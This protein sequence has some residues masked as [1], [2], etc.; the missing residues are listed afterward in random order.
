MAGNCASIA[1]ALRACL[2][3]EAAPPTRRWVLADRVSNDRAQPGFQV[4]VRLSSVPARDSVGRIAHV[5]GI[6]VNAYGVF[7]LDVNGNQAATAYQ[8]RSIFNAIYLEDVTG[9]AFWPSINARDILDDTYYRHFANISGPYLHTGNQ[10]TAGQLPFPYGPTQTGDAGIPA[11]AGGGTQ[12]FPIGFYAPLVTLGA[13]SNPLAGLI[14][15]AAIQRQSNQGAFR[16]RLGTSVAGS[17]G[18]V[19]L[20]GFKNGQDQPGL[21]VWLDVVYLPAL[22]VD[23]SWTL[24]SYTLPD[25][26]G[27]LR[28][29]EATTEHAHIRYYP[30]DDPSS[31]Q[32]LSGQIAC[33]NLDIFTFSVA[34]FI[35]APGLSFADEVTRTALFLY[36]ER[37][38]A[39]VRDN[40]AQDLPLFTTNNGILAP[41]TL[42]I[43]PYRQR[44]AGP[45]K[46]DVTFKYGSMG[47][48]AWVRY[49]HRTVDCNEVARADELAKAVGCDPCSR[50]VVTDGKGAVTSSAKSNTTLLVMDPAAM[51]GA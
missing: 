42:S 23:P 39:S 38:S 22:A 43:L 30:E 9:H 7:D 37:D 8:L 1:A 28:R 20:T 47:G 26:S 5:R 4:D 48:N 45:A 19:T 32:A 16:F 14:P 15:L 50:T 51:R 33:N 6:F 49:N 29:P 13:G 12:Q 41:T 25:S 36:S 27:V 10:G 3:C 18:G 46:G 35:E 21:D 2:P 44:G 11:N 24:D 17:P 34:G 40:A 31:G